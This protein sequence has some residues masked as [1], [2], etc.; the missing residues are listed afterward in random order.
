MIR[1]CHKSLADF[2]SLEAKAGAY[3]VSASE[4]D[5][6]L[7][8]HCWRAYQAGAASMGDY[9]ARHA[10][11][12]LEAA[13][14]PRDAE[15]L[16]ED[17]TFEKRRLEA[18]IE[19]NSARYRAFVKVSAPEQDARN[20]LQVVLNTIASHRRWHPRE[21]KLVRPLGPIEDYCEVWRFPCCGQTIVTGDGSPSRDRAD[22]CEGSPA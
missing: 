10:M 13:G 22:G 1:T 18:E 17:P 7:A 15:A 19:A 14:R 11:A 20:Q 4:G 8:D 16:C 5:R 9:E 21:A 2:I 6:M 3:Y 12:H